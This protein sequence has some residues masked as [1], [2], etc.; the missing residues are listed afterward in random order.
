VNIL[1]VDLETEWRGGQ[2]QALLLL[3]ALNAR[4]DCAELVTVKGSALGKRAARK[5]MK[6]HFVMPRAAR[7]S[8]ALK[9]RALTTRGSFDVV[10][11]N[12]AH[13]VTAAWLAG[14]HRRAAFVISRRVGYPLAKSPLACARYKA[15][16][17]IVAISQWVAERLVESG[18]PQEKISVVYEGVEIPANPRPQSPHLA[19]MHWGVA[20]VSDDARVARESPLLGCVGVLSPDKGHE[21]LIRALAQL[22]NEYRGCQL[23]LAGDG[24]SRPMLEG[25]AQELGVSKAVIFAGFVTD[26]ESVYPALDVFLFPSSFEGLG[27]S[28]LAAMSYAVPF[29]C[30]AF[31]EIIENE[32]SGLLVEPGSV[33]GLVKAVTRLLQDK[34]FARGIGAAG[35]ERIGKIFSCDH[36]VEEM[37]KV[38]RE[39]S[40]R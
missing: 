36:M 2:N 13:A 4:G 12:E 5:R 8:A 32:K 14:A 30:C 7:I 28:L 9:I 38:Y 21:L 1:L 29:Q 10:H 23:L 34:D 15:A 35:R 16:A 27:T 26:V 40:S 6:V 33:A 24:P 18:A 37:K 17:R 19:R 11:A 3:K 31:G 25:L 22:R 39:V 20:G